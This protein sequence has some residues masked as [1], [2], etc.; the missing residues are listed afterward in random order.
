VREFGYER[1]A[2]IRQYLATAGSDFETQLDELAR[3]LARPTSRRFEAEKAVGMMGCEM[4]ADVVPAPTG[5]PRQVS[6]PA[7]QQHARPAL[8]YDFCE[9]FDLLRR[10]VSVD[11][12]SPGNS[13]TAQLVTALRSN[14]LAAHEV[15][16]R[17]ARRDVSVAALPARF[18]GSSAQ[19][20]TPH[21]HRRQR[22]RLPVGACRLCRG[23]VRRL[24]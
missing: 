22:R 6:G 24:S 16:C 14:R 15:L 20:P 17:D 10:F 4:F 19:P 8:V 7:V 5:S 12:W 21:R 2:A 9:R 3:S 23:G 1:P 13:K 11:G 18:V